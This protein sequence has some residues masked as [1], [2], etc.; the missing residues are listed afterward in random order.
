M[1]ILVGLVKGM[2]ALMKPKGRNPLLLQIMACVGWIGGEIVGAVAGAIFYHLQNPQAEETGLI[3]YAYALLGAVIGAGI[4]F[5]IALC[6]PTKIYEG[7]LVVPT[8]IHPTNPFDSHNNP[9][10]PRQ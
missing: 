1:A 3:V 2:E 6:I 4:P 5:L 8:T 9:F 7:E 10:A